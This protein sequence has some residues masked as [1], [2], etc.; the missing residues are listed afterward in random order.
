MPIVR[1]EIP[2][3]IVAEIREN[4]ATFAE[5]H[6]AYLQEALKTG[7]F[8]KRW[9]WD[10]RRLAGNQ[11]PLLRECIAA[12]LCGGDHFHHE[13]WVGHGGDWGEQVRWTAWRGATIP[14]PQHFS[15]L[16][17][18]VQRLAEKVTDEILAPV[19]EEFRAEFREGLAE[20]RLRWEAWRRELRYRANRRDMARV[21]AAVQPRAA[22][23]RRHRVPR[24]LLAMADVWDG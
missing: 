15:D 6:C 11:R 14:M 4:A 3:G 10:Y 1:T 13:W 16:P 2:A 9:R 23:R 22:M 17:E 12:Y 21:S 8:S 7:S 20:A 19:E 5:T 24:H 18:E